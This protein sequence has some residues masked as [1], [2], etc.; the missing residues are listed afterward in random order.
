MTPANGSLAHLGM[1]VFDV[2]LPPRLQSPNKKYED[3]HDRSK[4]AKSYKETVYVLA[5]A[6]SREQGW[7]KPQRA[8]IHLLFG[9]KRPGR[10]LLQWREQYY[11]SDWDNGVASFKVGIDAI[12]NAGLIVDDDWEHLSCGGVEA[13][14]TDGP[15]IRVTLTKEG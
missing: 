12:K 9:L 13:T 10:A 2:P 7:V 4:A 8:T 6:A 14:F 5:L 11:P 3:W 1:L 15:W